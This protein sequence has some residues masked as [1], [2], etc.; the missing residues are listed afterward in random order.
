MEPTLG[1]DLGHVR[2]HTGDRA[3][4]SAAAIQAQAYT[5][6]RHIVFGSRQYAPGSSDGRRLLAHELTHV[7]QQRDNRTSV[8]GQLRLGDP[9]S[10]HERQAA[11]GERLSD[12]Q[13]GAAQVG[14]VQRQPNLPSAP[15]QTGQLNLSI[16][17]DGKVSVTVV[18]PNAPVVSN[19]SIGIRRNPDGKY[20]LL[21][22]GK[23]KTV[24]ASEIPSMLRGALG[25][26]GKTKP[27]EKPQEFYVPTCAQLR[28]SKDGRFFTFTE[29]KV[30]QMIAG[31][32]TPLTPAF[33]DALIEN[34]RP[35]PMEIDV[36]P[37]AEPPQEAVPPVSPEGTAVA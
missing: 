18:G 24:A 2:V 37:P 3:A 25:D 28:S 4:E 14:T 12:G 36:A 23:D 10:S 33:Y 7:A 27:G 31:K 16:G 32:T 34:C 11:R 20:D 1:H 15:S 6:G 13:A 22:G 30:N 17:D 9:D 19:P 35:K 5:V 29:Y 21:V 8:P 26:G